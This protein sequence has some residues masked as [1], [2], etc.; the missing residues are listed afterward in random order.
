M[1][2]FFQ[3]PTISSWVFLGSKILILLL[4]TTLIINRFSVG[5]I[6]L[7]YLYANIQGFAHLFDVGFSSTIIR[8]TAYSVANTNENS[9]SDSFRQLYGS[10]NT[11]FSVLLIFVLIFLVFVGNFSVLEIVNENGI[12]DGLTSYSIICVIMPINFFLKKNDAFIKGL[13]KVSLFNNWNAIMYF[14]TGIVTIVSILLDFS[15]YIVVL[16]NQVAILLNSIKN[17]ILLKSVTNF[18]F[19]VF[20]FSYSKNIL[21]EYWEPT[22][23]SALISFS[24]NGA[25]NFISIIIPKFLSVEIVASYLFSLRLIQIISEFS[26]APF[27]SNLPEFIKKFKQGRIKETADKA[28]RRLDWSIVLFVIGILFLAFSADFALTLVNAKTEFIEASLVSVLLI[29]FVLER[30]TA[31]HSQVVM[32]SNNIEHYKHYLFLASSYVIIVILSINSLGLYAIPFAY[33][34]SVLYPLIVILK[35]SLSVMDNSISIYFKKS[36]LKVLILLIFTS[37]VIYLWA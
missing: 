17:I 37:T 2:K 30:F 21:K 31:M 24:S 22:W 3:N 1:K 9:F 32:F 4:L 19:N 13:N 23:K 25:N 15:F 6:A 11:V 28:Y 8:F 5:E 26:W 36:V 16:I 10:M 33:I 20:Q 18:K 29:M 12:S 34:I 14:I 7:W 27:Y 35:R